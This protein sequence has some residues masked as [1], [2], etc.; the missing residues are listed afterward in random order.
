MG[1]EGL[2]AL[3][4]LPFPADET[5]GIV[6]WPGSEMEGLIPAKGNVAVPHGAEVSLRV[7][8]I[9]SIASADSLEA[10]HWI[11]REGKIRS[12]DSWS[13]ASVGGRWIIHGSSRPVDLRF[14]RNLPSANINELHLTSPLI[15]ESFDSIVHLAPGLR[16]LYLASTALTDEALQSVSKLHNLT[17]L[18]TWG[19]RFTDGGVQQLVALRKM[20]S[21]YLE[22]SS[23]SVTAFR[24][25]VEL[26]QL[27]RLG[28]QDV[29]VSAGGLKKL[30]ARL[31]HAKVG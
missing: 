25:A 23:L 6:A 29:A 9:E 17:Y 21:L 24:F 12:P 19:N 28:L 4:Y 8:I 10:G 14:L 31:P 11:Q 3:I 16:R 5:V 18:Q 30:R 7:M 13:R 26:P 1:F 22:E 2:V 15:P 20:E 27:S